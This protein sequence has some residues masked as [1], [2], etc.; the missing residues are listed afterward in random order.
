M[1]SEFEDLIGGGVTP[2]NAAD[3]YPGVRIAPGARGAENR[4][5]GGQ[6]CLGGPKIRVRGKGFLE[7]L[8]E[9]WIPVQAPPVFRRFLARLR[10]SVY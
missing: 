4:T 2:T 3:V 7:Q 5:R 8:I 6:I 10:G 9:G 1:P